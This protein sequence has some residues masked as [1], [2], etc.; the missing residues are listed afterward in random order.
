MAS[1]KEIYAARLAGYSNKEIARLYRVSESRVRGG[2]S[3]YS[4]AI[5]DVVGT[6]ADPFILDREIPAA[7][8]AK[9]ASREGRTFTHWRDLYIPPGELLKGETRRR[10]LTLEDMVNYFFRADKALI[11]R[12]GGGFTIID[13]WVVPV[14][15]GS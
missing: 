2:F 7:L 3:R 14:V 9:L 6:P 10:T 5:A 4:K 1:D 12:F 13:G 8:Q 15:R 11:T